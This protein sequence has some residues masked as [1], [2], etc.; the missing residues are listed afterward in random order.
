MVQ[1]IWK[2]NAVRTKIRVYKANQQL[3]Y[4]WGCIHHPH[5]AII[6]DKHMIKKQKILLVGIFILI[7]VLSAC[8]PVATSGQ[9]NVLNTQFSIQTSVSLGQTFTSRHDGLTG[10]RLYFST[11]NNAPQTVNLSLYDTPFKTKLLA[12]GSLTLEPGANDSYYS[13]PLDSPLASYMQDYYIELATVSLE[14]LGIGTAGLETYQDGTLYKD[15]SP[16]LAQLAFTPLYDPVK[17]AGGLINQAGIWLLWLLAGA[18]LF[19]IPGCALLLIFWR[20]S[21]KWPPLVRIP[22]GVAVSMSLYPILMLFTRIFKLQ[23]GIWY[24]ILPGAF[25]LVYFAVCWV[26]AGRPW[27]HVSF[28]QIFSINVL[29]ALT[30]AVVVLAIIFTRFWAIRALPLPMWGDTIHHTSIVQLMLQNGGLF[31][32]WAP[33]APMETM[34]YHFGFHAATAVFAWLTG[35]SAP[36]ATLVMGQWFNIFAVLGIY[37]LAWKTARR[38]SWAGIAA[39]AVAGLISFQPMF[40]VNWSRY[41]Q[42]AGQVILPFVIFTAWESAEGNAYSFKQSILLSFLAAGLA[43]THYRVAVFFLAIVPVLIVATIRKNNWRMQ[44]AYWATAGGAGAAFILPWIIKIYRGRLFT[45]MVAEVSR[46]VSGNGEFTQLYNAIGY[47]TNYMPSLLW[48]ALLLAVIYALWRKEK[49]AAIILSWWLILFLLANPATVGLP[50]TGA[51]SNFAVFIAIYIPASIFIGG[52]VSWLIEVPQ[53]KWPRLTQAAIALLVIFA[54]LAGAKSRLGDVQ[55]DKYALATRADIRAATWIKDNLPED[56]T[57][58]VNSFFAYGGS[59]VVG[60]DAGWWLPLLT[61]KQT[62]LPP[63]LYGTEQTPDPNYVQYVNSLRTLAETVGFT[64]PEFLAEL[65][66]REIKYAFI[67]QK[68]GGVNSGGSLVLNPDELIASGKYLPI[69]HQDAVWV[70]EI[71]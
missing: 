14:P 24:A 36:Q 53:A 16:V 65:K 9:S 13:I 68:R 49:G 63:M 3:R 31:D 32:S 11:Q 47:F 43:L 7:L 46:P 52:A 61:G 44:V 57:L 10:I 41:T 15:N 29:T 39:I 23:L 38:N 27:P 64:N 30:A 4:T 20:S 37:A 19:I 62:S 66:A 21:S 48:L 26:R 17:L 70:F 34:N 2:S 1:W 5:T 51:I 56:A 50:G 18:Y 40:Y 69:Y 28:K 71:Q 33:L 58:L 60:S 59:T 25:G 54:S 55:P 67:G 42:L 12:S 8:S 22:G 45:H 35:V 6:R